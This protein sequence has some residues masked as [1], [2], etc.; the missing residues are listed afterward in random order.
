MTRTRGRRR[1]WVEKGA[2]RLHLVD[3]DGRKPMPVQKTGHP[4]RPEFPVPVGLRGIRTEKTI[5]YYLENG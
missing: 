2:K 4:D 3:L 1:R 5:R